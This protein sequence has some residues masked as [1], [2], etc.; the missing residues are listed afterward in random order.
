MRKK[1]PYVQ[2]SKAADARVIP[3]TLAQNRETRPPLFLGALDDLER[4][5]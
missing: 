1:T 3:E 4:T 5:H 2:E